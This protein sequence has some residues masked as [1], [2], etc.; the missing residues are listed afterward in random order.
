MFGMSANPEENPE[1]T[2]P[3]GPQVSGVGFENDGS[4]DTIFRFLQAVVFNSQAEGLIGFAQGDV[5]RRN[6]EQYLLA[7]DSDLAP[8]AGQQ[9]TL[10]PDNAASVGP[11]IDLFIARATTPFV[12]KILG[13]NTTECSLVA[14]TVVNGAS[15]SYR[16]QPNMMFMSPSGASISDANLRALANVAGQE[17][18]YTC[19][20]PG[21]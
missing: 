1:D 17:I 18:T 8:I 4:V 5:Q 20:P 2:G 21:W 7:F 11:R 15:A 9:V 19:L 3:T 6:V 16:L 12:S 14:R 13:G 10:R